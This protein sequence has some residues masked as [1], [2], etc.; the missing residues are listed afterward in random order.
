MPKYINTTSQ[1]VFKDTSD[2]NAVSK[3]YVDAGLD[4]K[5]N[6]IATTTGVNIS[7][8]TP[9][10]YG[11]YATPQTGNITVSLT[12]AVRGVDQILYHD[13]SVAPTITVTGGTA[14]KFGTASYDLTKVN[15]IAFWFMGGTN[16]GY[17]ITPAV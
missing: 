4:G 7:L 5:Q 13:D 3:S 6:I 10:E 15:V 14:V 16:V 11:S 17:I 8:V 1:S 9:Q 2:P 12:N